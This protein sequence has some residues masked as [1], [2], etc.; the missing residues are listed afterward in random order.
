MR[1]ILVRLTPVKRG[2]SRLLRIRRLAA[3]RTSPAAIYPIPKLI[4]QAGEVGR[5]LGRRAQERLW[6]AWHGSPT[7]RFLRTRDE[8]PNPVQRDTWRRA[9]EV[10]TG[11]TLL[12]ISEETTN[13]ALADNTIQVAVDQIRFLGQD[14]RFPLVKE[15]N[16]QYGYERNLYG[17]AAG[18][19]ARFRWFALPL[20]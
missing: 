11:V 7:T 15:E 3:Q 20:W 9:I 12:T 13:P 6:D 17:C 14:T 5:N 16:I 10:T 2:Q 19:A 1:K 4:V 8:A 18:L